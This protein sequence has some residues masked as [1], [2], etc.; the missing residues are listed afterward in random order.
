MRCDAGAKDSALT[1][2]RVGHTGI[3]PAAKAAS[4][5]SVACAWGRPPSAERITYDACSMPSTPTATAWSTA[6]ARM[7][8]GGDR[9][10]GG[11]RLLD[12]QPQVLDR[13]L[14]DE[15]VGARRDH[16]AAC[17]HFDHLNLSLHP[18]PYGS[19]DLACVA[20]FTAEEAAVSAR[21]GDRWT[22]GNDPGQPVVNSPLRVSPFHYVEM[23]VAEV[24]TVVTPAAS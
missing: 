16:A 8:V 1:P 15:H 14:R 10:T 13:E 3:P 18:L 5:S 6:V 22:G 7:R 12:Q 17:H 2:P 21:C 11:V 20:H 19:H 4:C 24:R 23:P 9:R